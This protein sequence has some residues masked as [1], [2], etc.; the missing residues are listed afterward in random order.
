MTLIDGPPHQARAGIGN[1]RRPCVRYQR[2][3]SAPVENLEHPLDTSRLVVGVE[4]D[5]LLGDVV[6]LQQGPRVPRIFSENEVRIAKHT[7]GAKRHVFEIPDRRCNEVERRH[8]QSRLECS[9]NR[10][11]RPAGVASHAPRSVRIALTRR[12]GVTSKA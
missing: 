9:G 4:R 11:A 5:R 1:E 2:N 12:A 7:H 8:V 10:C 3:V 6:S